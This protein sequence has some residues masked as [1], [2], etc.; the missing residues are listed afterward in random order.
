MTEKEW[1]SEVLDWLS[2]AGIKIH[3][4]DYSTSMHHDLRRELAQ[5][6]IVFAGIL[7]PINSR[8]KFR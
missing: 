7:T 3:G 4:E 5:S 2:S 6:N 1:R 8:G